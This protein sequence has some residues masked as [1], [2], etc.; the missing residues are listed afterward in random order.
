MLPLLFTGTS[1][2]RDTAATTHCAASPANKTAQTWRFAASF[3][4]AWVR[5]EGSYSSTY[6]IDHASTSFFLG[7]HPRTLM[8]CTNPLRREEERTCMLCMYVCMYT[9]LG[10]QILIFFLLFYFKHAYHLGFLL[11][12]SPFPFLPRD[13]PS[14]WYKVLRHRP[15]GCMC[16]M[17]VKLRRMLATF[18]LSGSTT[19]CSACRAS[20]SE[21]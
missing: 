4:V 17:N 9:F 7:V 8:E 3:T 12:F 10:K 1:A 6:D 19:W 2:A 14:C 21:N 5:G 15:P 13:C 16:R 18:A 20:V 11:F